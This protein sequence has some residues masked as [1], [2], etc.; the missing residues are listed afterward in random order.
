[1]GLHLFTMEYFWGLE[2]IR[3]LVIYF[4]LERVVKDRRDLFRQTLKTLIPYLLIFV[5]TIFWRLFI[6][7]PID[8]PNALRWLSMLFDEPIKAII[9]LVEMVLGDLLFLMIA[10]W[11]DTLRVELIDLDSMFL[12]ASW[13][14]VIFVGTILYFYVRN[15]KQSDVDSDDSIKSKSQMAILGLLVMLLGPLPV[16][17]TN[18]QI[19]A[20]RF[21]D[22]FAL[23]AMLGASILLVVIFELIL[24][25][26]LMLVVLV[27][28][29]AGLATG[30]HVRIANEYRWAWTKQR[31]F[32]WQL[33]WRVPQLESGTAIFSDGGIFT[34]TGDYPVSFA[35]GLL[36]QA[37][38]ELETTQ[39]PYWFFEL[40]SGFNY[41]QKYFLRGHELHGKLRNIAFDGWSTDSIIIDYDPDQGSCL[42]VVGEGD[43]L[44]ETL[45]DLT[46][47]AL[48][49]ADLSRISLPE[50]DDGE[51]GIPALFGD[52]P[53]HTWCYYFQKAELAR[54]FGDWER[55]VELAKEVDRQQ[56]S[57]Q[58]RFEWRPFVDAYLHLGEYQS[59][60][61]NTTQAFQAD[62]DTGEM[63]CSLWRS[64]LDQNP[65]DTKLADFTARVVG[66]LDCPE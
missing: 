52:A 17:L 53:P 24:S 31:R 27:C 60:Y 40:D 46:R 10:T 44:V 42:W 36:Y 66:E 3:P 47:S 35:L 21:S 62:D 29:L 39:P 38:N 25:K 12:V 64:T 19:I 61:A 14:I 1:Q 15:L 34:Y 4:V 55:V 45:P 9:H 22:R 54:Q 20:G 13:G 11:F 6:Y 5:S 65:G 7:A 28:A 30:S 32:Y 49:M 37:E 41:Y 56:F 16:W 63:F 58:N 2:L 23:A 33:K 43:E 18:K 48:P 57:P 59:A 50:T 8:D 51:M 26:R